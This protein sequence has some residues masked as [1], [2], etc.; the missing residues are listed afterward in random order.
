M[1]GIKLPAQTA[2]GMTVVSLA[3]SG[4]GLTDVGVFEDEKVYTV[5]VDMR[6]TPEDPAPSCTLQYALLQPPTGADSASLQVGLTPPYPVKTE[7]PEMNAELIRRYIRRLV[8]VYATMGT[9]GKL[10]KLSV[11]ESPDVRFNRPIIAAL[12]HWSF[13]PAQLNS[14]PVALKVLIGI[15]ILPFE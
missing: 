9:D 6:A 5:Y 14:Q 2:Y 3:S 15:P 4:G 8:I 12:N 7:I 1:D 11:R 13:R 10:Q